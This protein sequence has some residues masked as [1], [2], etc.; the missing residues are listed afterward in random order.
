MI[1]VHLQ[2]IA[3]ELAGLVF[4]EQRNVGAVVTE[5]PAEIV[6]LIAPLGPHELRELMQRE[7]LN[8][9]QLAEKLNVSPTVISMV[10]TGSKRSAYLSRRIREVFGQEAAQYR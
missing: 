9:K 1:P 5:R 7:R 2:I 4:G 3:H 6:D 10:A 8:Q